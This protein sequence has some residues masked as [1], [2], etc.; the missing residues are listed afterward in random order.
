MARS[1]VVLAERPVVLNALFG[2]E[3]EI[4]TACALLSG[5]VGDVAA[6]PPVVA[7]PAVRLL[8]LTGP[9]GVGKTRLAAAV[10]DTLASEYPDGI[11]WTDLAGVGTPAGVVPAIAR[12]L[13]LRAEGSS[14]QL[15]RVSASIRALQIL[16]VLDNFEHLLEAAPMVVDLLRTCPQLTMLV[17][18]RERLHVNG[19]R[20]QPVPPLPLPSVEANTEMVLTAPAVRLFVDRAHAVS[21]G[22]PLEGESAS[23]VAAICRRL[24][25]LPLAIELAA[26]RVKVLP[27]AELLARLDRRL[28]LLS[29]GPRDV[30]ARLRTMR[31]AIAW[32]YDLLTPEE[33]DLFRRLAVF[34]DGFTIE[35]AE[36]VM[37]GGGSEA[38]SPNPNSPSFV[39]ELV[40]TLVEK[41]LLVVDQK[42]AG[43]TRYAMLEIIREFGLE[44]LAAEG[45]L[46]NVRQSHAAFALALAERVE[47]VL[48]GGREQI[49]CLDLLDREW[50]NLSEALVW[51][52]AAGEHEHLRAL[53]LATALVRFWFVRG[54]LAEGRDW[55]ERTLA[56]APTAPA[57]LMAKALSGLAMLAWAQGDGVRA[58][59]ALD[60]ALDN[61]D[62]ETDLPGLAF[63]RLT[64]GYLALSQGDFALAAERAVE[65]KAHYER[66]GRRWEQNTADFCLARAALGRGDLRRAGTILEELTEHAREIGDVYSLASAQ[67]T[68]GIVRQAQGDLAHALVLHASALRAYRDLREL[69]NVAMCLEA[70]ASAACGLGDAAAAARLLGVSESLRTRIGAPV[71]APER[72]AYDAAV[73][74]IRAALGEPEFNE[75]R[76]AGTTAT[77]D[78]A[79]ATVEALAHASSAASRP[80]IDQVLPFGLSPREIEVLRLIARG[81]TDHEIAEAFSVSRRTVHTHVAGILNKLAAQNRTAAVAVA[82]RLGIA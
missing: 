75:N 52:G 77:L 54:Y 28:P 73:A 50:S 32:S 11:A 4:T 44:Q 47:P 2:R 60:A 18:S 81:K 35:D 10:A 3:I 70:V 66:A 53:R 45:D 40:S 64:E 34:V 46:E 65:S 61:I 33:R 72:A 67:F 71:L 12:S 55:L 36:A 20:E 74:A 78:E 15:E 22:L 41:S 79:I 80:D 59:A 6:T 58:A 37:V 8:T 7:A 57:P 30:P 27:P 68:L 29:D 25:G 31:D 38:P 49:T 17:T 48:Y 14:S 42:A 39:L 63:A 56:A 51:L 5:A 1:G 13:G 43:G 19:E 26:A 62:E 76:A 69:W 23:V 24:D 16:L 82:V 9:A 21:P